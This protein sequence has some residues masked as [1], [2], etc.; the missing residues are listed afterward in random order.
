M[1][2]SIESGRHGHNPL[3]RWLHTSQP[4]RGNT[5]ESILSAMSEAGLCEPR[6]VASDQKLFGTIAYYWALAPG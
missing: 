1:E 2:V 6:T 4:M 3:A 5:L